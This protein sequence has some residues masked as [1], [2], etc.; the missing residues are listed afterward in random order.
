MKSQASEVLNPKS[1]QSQNRLRQK[2]ESPIKP[3]GVL[4]GRRFT[5][6]LFQRNRPFG[7]LRRRPLLC[8]CQGIN[9]HPANGS[10]VTRVTQWRPKTR[11]FRLGKA[12]LRQPS[13]K[14]WR[15]ALACNGIGA[16]PFI[17][18]FGR[19]YCLPSPIA[20]GCLSPLPPNRGMETK[21]P[22]TREG[23]DHQPSRRGAAERAAGVALRNRTGPES[24][25]TPARKVGTEIG[26][27]AKSLK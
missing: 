3:L 12:A 8:G 7:D 14:E 22:R 13:D 15:G 18:E 26:M 19:A 2:F 4:H 6:V 24:W 5:A 27:T 25:N 10:K 16:E 20:W 17:P 23:G 9:R 1:L 11:P 21:G